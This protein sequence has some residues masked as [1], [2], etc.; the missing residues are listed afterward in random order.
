M[1]KFLLSERYKL[2]VHWRK[3]LYSSPGKCLLSD[4]Y[5]S[6]PVL[7]DAV[8][9]NDNDHIMLDFFSQ[10]FVIVENVYVAKLS[11]GE[12]IYNKNGTIT[13]K[14]AM[15]SHDTELNRVPKLEDKDYLVIDTKDHEEAVHAQN[16]LYKTYVVSPDNEMYNFRSK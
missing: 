9:L 15:I 16:L 7:S 11:W 14:N 10:Y 5:F 1:D 13:L 4:A 3:A 8:R 6:G 2:E 12:V